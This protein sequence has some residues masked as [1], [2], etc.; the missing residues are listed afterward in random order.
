LIDRCCLTDGYPTE[1]ETKPKIFKKGFFKKKYISNLKSEKEPK[2]RKIAQAI[3]LLLASKNLHLKCFDFIFQ[4]LYF[5]ISI[6][7]FE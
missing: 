5:E 6:E 7:V 2:T 3:G 1:F 4:T